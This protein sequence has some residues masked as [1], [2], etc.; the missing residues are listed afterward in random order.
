MREI[1]FFFLV[2][3]AFFVLC[4]FSIRNREDQRVFACKY[5]TAKIMAAIKMGFFCCFFFNPEALT[6]WMH[7]MKWQ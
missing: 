1:R 7:A 3:H 6:Q 4:F 2:K 5:T